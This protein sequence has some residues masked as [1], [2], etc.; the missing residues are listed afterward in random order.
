MGRY[1]LHALP[2]THA[3]ESDVWP[4]GL[5]LSSVALFQGTGDTAGTVYGVQSVFISIWNMVPICPTYPSA[6]GRKYS[7]RSTV[8]QILMNGHC[9]E[10]KRTYVVTVR[11]VINP[12]V[13]ARSGKNWLASLR[14]R[15]R[16]FGR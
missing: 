10:L 4:H 13:R 3:N 2:S 5:A 1:A 7:E 11:E 8:F 6:S 9:M 16:K 12:D 15:A 14:I